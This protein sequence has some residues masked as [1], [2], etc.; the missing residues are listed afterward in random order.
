MEPLGLTGGEV[1]ADGPRLGLVEANGPDGDG[2]T[3]QPTR[4]TASRSAAAGVL[5]GTLIVP[6]RDK[7][8][9]PCCHTATA[10]K[11]R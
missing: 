3:E 11:V 9:V 10:V 5:P 6:L 7:C 4:K 2:A 1:S 8:D